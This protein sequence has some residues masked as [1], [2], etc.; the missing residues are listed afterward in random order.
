MAQLQ[1]LQ[2]ALVNDGV[3]ASEATCTMIAITDSIIK[4]PSN[5]PGRPAYQA[6]VEAISNAA[7][8]QDAAAADAAHGAV[9]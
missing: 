3:P 9:N 2:Q 4:A 7:V 1:V 8:L 6:A 5:G